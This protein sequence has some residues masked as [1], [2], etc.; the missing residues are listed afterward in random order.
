M[1]DVTWYNDI[2]FVITNM[3]CHHRWHS[4]EEQAE[5]IRRQH[6]VMFAQLG[7]FAHNMRE[8]DMPL[9]RTKGWLVGLDWLVGLI[10]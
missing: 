1:Y 6:N 7:T 5:T 10:G 9:E 3:A 4:E 8:F 2:A